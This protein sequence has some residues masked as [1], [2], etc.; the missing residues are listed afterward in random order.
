[1]SAEGAKIKAPQAP[2][3]GCGRGIHLQ[4]GEESG[5]RAVPSSEKIFEFLK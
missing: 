1:V 5:E 2:R 4:L 3:G